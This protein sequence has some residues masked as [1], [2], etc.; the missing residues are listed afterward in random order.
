MRLLPFSHETKAPTHRT[1]TVL[2][3]TYSDSYVILDTETTGLNPSAD[4]IIQLSAI[5]YNS[6]GV[7][8]DFY[9]TY[10]NPGF[11]I[12]HS[13][14]KINGITDSMVANAPRAEQIRS[15]FLSFLGNTLIV[16]YNIIFDLRFL[17]HTF[18][19]AFT[20]RSYVDVL[21]ISR[22]LLFSPDY[23]LETVSS[24][25]D[26]E[27]EQ[28]FHD[29]FSDCEAVAAILHYLAEPNLLDNFEKKFCPTGTGT[30]STKNYRGQKQTKFVTPH[31]F[32]VEELHSSVKHPLFMKNIV[33]TGELK[34]PRYEAAQAAVDCG[35]I[36]KTAVSGKTNYLVVGTQ[37]LDV[38]GADGMSSKERKAYELNDRG[39]ASIKIISE[40]EFL[41]LLHGKEV[42]SNE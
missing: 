6:T 31:F 14:S 5:K 13:A 29:S 3:C 23:K 41:A 34:M 12:P 32:T 10:L 37:N 36:L 42:N 16:G 20:G 9:N 26:F 21:S 15:D 27:P 25:I 18:S 8:I 28:G 38:V 40:Y 11:S 2:S 1:S 17:N 30:S 33:F 22:Q 35:A 19:G 7:P 4:K 39:K 24:R